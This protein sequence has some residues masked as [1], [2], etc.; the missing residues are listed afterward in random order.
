LMT[1][2]ACVLISGTSMTVTNDVGVKTFHSSEYSEH[3]PAWTI[4]LGL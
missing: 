3:A 1:S 4:R 2:S